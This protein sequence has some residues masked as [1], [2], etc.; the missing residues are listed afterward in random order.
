MSDTIERRTTNSGMAVLKQFFG[1]KDGQT[2]R[3]FASEVNALTD[4]D[5][6]QLVGG[7]QD[8]SF[9]Y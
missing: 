8:E 9:D 7:I 6:A 4:E 1:T 2:L 5:K 3:E